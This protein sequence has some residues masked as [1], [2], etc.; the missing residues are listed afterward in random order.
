MTHLGVLCPPVGGHIN[1]F[2]P[3]CH[4]LKKRG[5]R[6]SVFGLSNLQEKTTSADLEF[7][8]LGISE[9]PPGAVEKHLACLGEL[10]GKAALIYTIK[11]YTQAAEILLREGPQTIREAGV[12]ALLV[13]QSLLEAGT[14]AEHLNIP[15]I[16]ICSALL[17]NPDL[18]IPPIWFPWQYSP[19]WWAQL[20]NLGGILFVAKIGTSL[21]KLIGS[22]RKQWNLPPYKTFDDVCSP[23]AQ[24]SQE[25]VEFEFPRSSLP[26]NFH[27]TG[28]FANMVSHK[29]VNFPF[30]KLTGQR[31]IYASLGTVQNRLLWVFQAITEA[32][33]DLDVQLVISLGS[34]ANFESTPRH[35]GTS[36]VVNYAPQLE[37]LQK[38]AL[39]I[40]HAGLNS[41]MEALSFGVP[42]VA[43]PIANDQP[44]VAARI[45]WTGTGEVVPLP[46]LNVSRLRA[47]ITKVLSENSYK[48][49]ALRLKE[50]IH[51]AQGVGGAADIVEKA[52]FTGKPVYR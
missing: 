14:I 18:K 6:I 11:L 42:M 25:P 9:Y 24:I 44:G 4:E 3:L 12:D 16:T 46:H 40:T 17:M 5:Y 21:R 28:P 31:L 8:A 30:E 22:Q 2:I 52:I 35:S 34:T 38:A 27:F 36:I 48:K 45:A 20:R 26:S 33:A 41:A 23:L 49:N 13:D 15:F 1:T 50:A 7:W 29:P 47:A 43:I 19:S 32:C 37:I 51:R 39:M 10:S